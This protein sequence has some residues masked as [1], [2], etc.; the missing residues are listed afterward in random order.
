MFKNISAEFQ[1]VNDDTNKIKEFVVNNLFSVNSPNSLFKKVIDDFRNKKDDSDKACFAFVDSILDK[2]SGVL[3][4][5]GIGLLL[6]DKS[7]QGDKMKVKRLTL[8]FIINSARGQIS[9]KIGYDQKKDFTRAGKGFK[10]KKYLPGLKDLLLK[11]EGNTSSPTTSAGKPG[12]GTNVQNTN[13]TTTT[14]NNSNSSGTNTENTNQPTSG[15]NVNASIRYL[16]T[17]ILNEADAPVNNAGSTSANSS[18]NINKVIEWVNNSIIGDMSNTVKS[19]KED[20]IKAYV[21]KGGGSNVGEYKQGDMVTYKMKY[22]KEGVAPDQQKDM[23]GTKKIERIEGENI[24]FKDKDGKEFIKTKD[25]I[26][27][28]AEGDENDGQESA[29]VGELKQKLSSIKSD[30]NKMNMVNQVVDLVN[31]PEGEQKIKSILPNKAAA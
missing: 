27:G 29:V 28:K 8:E 4:T 22:F 17:S 21:N 9:K 30:S 16:Y 18:G 14:T 3:G 26:I 23:V 6:N 11:R 10:D 19:M 12:E 2:N 13:S 31:S 15:S 5:Q 7:L 20:D 24:I 25:Q 1:K